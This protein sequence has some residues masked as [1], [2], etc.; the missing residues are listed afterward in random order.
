MRSGEGAIFAIRRRVDLE[1]PGPRNRFRRTDPQGCIL[2]VAAAFAV[3]AMARPQW[4]THEETVKV[5]GL[6]VMFVLDLS[7]S[8]EVEDA[9]PSRL[10]KA[11]HLIK[12]MVDRLG[13]DRVG[14]GD[15]RGE[16]SGVLPADDGRELHAGRASDH[17]PCN[18]RD[19]RNGY[20]LGARNCSASDG[21]RGRRGGRPRPDLR[22]LMRS[23]CFRTARTGKMPQSTRRR[24]SKRQAISSIFSESAVKRAGR[25]QFA[26]KTEVS[27]TYK[28]D[29]HGQPI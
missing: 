10:M 1:D 8:M 5:S 29:H 27:S 9:I 12:S 25:F 20:R 19:S 17:E 24:K 15:F 28:K 2:D 16:R 3:I 4:G 23:C 11:K 18:G 13:G 7:N 6:D 14:S 26:T 22:C 21:S